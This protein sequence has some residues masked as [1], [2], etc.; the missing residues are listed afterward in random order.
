M[1]KRILHIFGAGVLVIAAAATIS[2]GITAGGGYIIPAIISAIAD[3]AVA[4]Y[5]YKSEQK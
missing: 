5:F 2:A 3:G 1:R 4:V